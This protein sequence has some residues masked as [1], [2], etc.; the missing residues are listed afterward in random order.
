MQT[1][2]SPHG[3]ASLPPFSWDG[4]QPLTVMTGANGI[5][6]SHLLL[7]IAGALGGPTHPTNQ[8]LGNVEVDGV[9]V[10]SRRP[11]LVG[12]LPAIW[13]TGPAQAS[14]GAMY[15]QVEPIVR[16][17]RRAARARRNAATSE[18]VTAMFQHFDDMSWLRDLDTARLDALGDKITHADILDMRGPYG[19]VNVEP[20]DPIATVTRLFFAHASARVTHLL[21]GKAV[22]EIDALVGPAPWLRAAT[23]LATFDVAFTIEPPID[24][25]FEYTLTCRLRSNDI[26]GPGDLSS[27]EQAILALVATIVVGE[28]LAGRG[29]EG[30]G[31]L[32]LDEPDAH[33]HTSIIKDFIGHLERLVECGFQIIMVTHRP[34]TM[35]LCPPDSLVEMRRESDQLAFEPVPPARRPALIG[36]LAADTVAVLPSVRIVLVEADADAAFH[37]EIYRQAKAI[38]ALPSVPP[39]EFKP[40]NRSGFGGKNLV[41]PQMAAMQSD[42]LTAFYRGLVDGDNETTS[43][44][45][46]MYR[47]ARYAIE[48]YW[49]D[50]LALY[51]TVVNDREVDTRLGFAKAGG[52]G[53]GELMKLRDLDEPELQRIADLVLA[54]FTGHITDD[55]E[56]EPFTLLRERGPVSLQYP[57]WVRTTPKKVFR[58]RVG[59]ALDEAILRDA[60]G[61][62]EL[63]GLVPADLVDSY[64]VLTQR[65]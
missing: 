54:R 34:E 21:Q 6:K 48:N 17:A 57:R 37:Q 46:G 27:G 12:Y 4:I 56:R 36:R 8:L 41:P 61:G 31:V 39:L 53:R 1:L 15:G 44:P 58:R 3:L 33:V 7:L 18:P 65:M 22:A 55:L 25:R 40:A 28:T 13:A 52:I 2:R 64:L 38:K 45:L 50:P 29:G 16:A 60:P 11:R 47:L 35:L 20:A 5:G 10:M 62:P 24:V 63:A 42:G 30:G 43:L 26:V 59:A 32:L 49:F 9:Q 23:L 51:C 19:F 14:A